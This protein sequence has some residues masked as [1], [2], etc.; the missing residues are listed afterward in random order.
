MPEFRPRLGQPAA[1]QIFDRPAGLLFIAMHTCATPGPTFFS[2]GPKGL[3]HHDRDGFVAKLNLWYN[4]PRPPSSPCAPKHKHTPAP[5][6]CVQAN[7][8]RGAL[9]MHEGDLDGTLLCTSLATSVARLLLSFA[10]HHGAPQ[11]LLPAGLDADAPY[12]GMW[13]S[14]AAAVSLWEIGGGRSL[15]SLTF[16]GQQGARATASQASLGFLTPP[17]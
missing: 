1:L 12:D 16:G 7:W 9:T 5:T 4:P 17:K 6:V 13:G 11:H 15:C 2:W 3:F 14:W 10:A 8:V